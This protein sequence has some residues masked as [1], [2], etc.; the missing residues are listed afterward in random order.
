M[1]QTNTPRRQTETTAKI[2]L[3]KNVDT[4]AATFSLE[5]TLR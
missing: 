5:T 2:T 3:D 4:D 1:S